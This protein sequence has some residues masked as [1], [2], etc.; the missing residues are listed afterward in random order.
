MFGSRPSERSRGPRLAIF[1]LS[2]GLGAPAVVG[3]ASMGRPS[4]EAAAAA[5][6]GCAC[7]PTE[8]GEAHEKS[9]AAKPQTL[10]QAL[11]AYLDCLHSPLSQRGPGMN[12]AAG[13]A[14]TG[15]SRNP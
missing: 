5:P 4:D 12:A 2:L 8:G 14:Y 6:A 13:P 3:C 9:L 15:V 1:W 11:R 10:V 7:R